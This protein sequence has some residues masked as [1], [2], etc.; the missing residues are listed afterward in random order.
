[1]R[2]ISLFSLRNRA[3]ECLISVKRVFAH[4]GHYCCDMACFG[5]LL[6][7]CIFIREKY[8]RPKQLTLLISV[9]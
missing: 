1:M 3:N 7:I 4:F 2:G 5:L 9:Q 6:H 8:D